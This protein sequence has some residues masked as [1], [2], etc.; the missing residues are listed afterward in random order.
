V[1]EPTGSETQVVVRLA[2][3]PVI[4][5]FRERISARPGERIGIAPDPAVAHLFDEGS[6]MRLN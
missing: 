2:G 4:C 1:V 3:G 5:A 6:G